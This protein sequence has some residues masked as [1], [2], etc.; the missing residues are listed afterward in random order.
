[1]SVEFASTPR[2]E[3]PLENA[4]PEKYFERQFSIEVARACKPAQVVFHMVAQ[5]LDVPRE[6]V[7]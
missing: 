4:N 6:N 5:E 1:L 2:R 3:E 7:V